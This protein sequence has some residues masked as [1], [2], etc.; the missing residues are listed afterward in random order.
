MI[1]ALRPPRAAAA[2]FGMN[3]RPSMLLEPHGRGLHLAVLD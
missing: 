3:A 2:P 1:S